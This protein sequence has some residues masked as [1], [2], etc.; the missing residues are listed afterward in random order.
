MMS[1]LCFPTNSTDLCRP[2]DIC[3]FGLLTMAWHLIIS[4]LEK[5][6]RRNRQVF[7][8]YLNAES[9]L[10]KNSWKVTDGLWILVM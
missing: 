1:G 6:P 5:D 2:L 8:K 10:E 3:L 9:S 7:Q 4:I